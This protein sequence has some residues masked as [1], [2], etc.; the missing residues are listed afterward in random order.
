MS[1]YRY[2][3]VEKTVLTVKNS[4][5]LFVPFVLMVFLSLIAGFVSATGNMT[6]V[7]MF[8]G[9][10]LAML[11]AASKK[12]LFWFVLIG[13]IV[14]V[15]LSQLYFPA[16]KYIRYVIPLAVFGLLFHALLSKSNSVTSQQSPLSLPIIRW[17]LAFVLFTLISTIINWSGVGSAVLGLKGYF[18]VWGLL[19]VFLLLQ[20]RPGFI[21]SLP[22][23]I[24]LIAFVQLPFVLHQYIFLVPKRI[25]IDPNII[26]VDIVAGTFGASMMGGGANAALAAFL[27]VVVACVVGM[28]KRGVVSTFVMIVVSGILLIPVFLNEAKV[29]VVYLVLVFIVLFFKDIAKAPMRFILVSGF[30]FVLLV[31][32]VST[33]VAL[34]PDKRISSWQD[35]VMLSVERQL[36]SAEERKGQYGELSRWTAL[37]FWAQEH[38][39]KYFVEAVVGHGAGASRDQ[40]HGLDIADT[41]AENN[42]SG[43][44]I[45]YTAVAAV[46]WDTGL[47]GLVLVLGLFLAA[48]R[49]AGHLAKLH[50]ATPWRAGVF[51][52]LR[53]GIAILT[54]SLAHK[55]FFAYQ[56]PFQTFLIVVFGYLAYWQYQS[57][58]STLISEQHADAFKVTSTNLIEQK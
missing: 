21:D 8:V 33:L 46:L 13:G 50:E 37:T 51:D 53:A 17:A 14:F 49:T 28:W 20:W 6:F 31:G 43:L 24:L 22:K 2:S 4:I 9:V 29:S 12:A 41:L 36:A 56:I 58:D 45:G 42:Y 7:A 32:M 39:D 47:V 40:L 11:L 18:Q 10:V 19:F 52:G 48:F 1:L 44:R 54:F 57:K 25:G 30:A 55:D 38:S 23:A 3:L 15:G 26:P 27:F 5:W 34:H 16:G 35:L